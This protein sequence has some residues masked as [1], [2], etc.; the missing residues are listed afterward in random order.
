MSRESSLLRGIT[1]KDLKSAVQKALD[2][3][4]KFHH[5]NGSTQAVIVWPATEK[6]VTFSP[7]ASRNDAHKAFIAQVEAIQGED[8]FPKHK[9]GKPRKR[10]EGSG[11]LKTWTDHQ[12][13]RAVRED[14]HVQQWQNKVETLL[15]EHAEKVLMVRIYCCPPVT[16]TDINHVVHLL[17]RITHIEELLD[18]IEYP[19]QRFTPPT[20]PVFGD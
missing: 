8:L 12:N 20:I 19:Y 4:W 17:R 1:H 14:F 15:K 10:V 3:G 11:F 5:M 9:H 16:N 2:K 18:E 13:H 6:K 7:T